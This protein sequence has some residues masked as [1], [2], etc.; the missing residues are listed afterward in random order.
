M[1]ADLEIRFVQ[2]GLDSASLLNILGKMQ[3]R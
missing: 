3:S 2:R 1:H